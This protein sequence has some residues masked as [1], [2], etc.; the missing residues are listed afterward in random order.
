MEKIILASIILLYSIPSF[1]QLTVDKKEGSSVV[2][3]L[4][5]G[6]KVNDGSTLKRE[7]TTIND[8]SCPVQL[9]G[10]GIE[11]SYAS[12]SYAFKPIG[13]L[14]ANEP[15]AAYEVVHLIYNVFGEHMKSLSNTEIIDINGQKD[16]SKYSSWYASENNV[17]EYLICVSYVSNV[18]TQSGKLWHYNFK[19]LKDQLNK[20]EIAFDEDYVP[21][22][23]R[24]KEK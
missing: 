4:S 6:I 17:S 8:A 10:V 18:R 11:T 19:A 9:N 20:L 5:M 12:S 3:K 21:K 22:K 2:T 16:F 1:S 13:N 7:Y 14:I 15:I 23:D 24:E